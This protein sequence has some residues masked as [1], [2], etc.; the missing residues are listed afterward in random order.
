MRYAVPPVVVTGNSLFFVLL[1]CLE[2][3]LPL[4]LGEG[5]P[6]LELRTLGSLLMSY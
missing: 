2:L 3:A 4:R 6:L 1:G 5:I